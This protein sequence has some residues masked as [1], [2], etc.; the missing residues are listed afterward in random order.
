MTTITSKAVLDKKISN[1]QHQLDSMRREN[2]TFR[3]HANSHFEFVHNEVATKQD[4]Y[5]LENRLDNRLKT[6]LGELET[7]LTQIVLKIIEKIGVSS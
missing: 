3:A 4:L 5:E 6:S 1:I 7:R 2:E